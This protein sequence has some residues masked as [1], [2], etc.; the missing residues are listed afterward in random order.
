MHKLEFWSTLPKI[1]YLAKLDSGGGTWFCLNLV[2]Q[3]FVTLKERTIPSEEW[4]GVGWW[5]KVWRQE[6]RKEKKL[7]LGHKIF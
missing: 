2:S 3:N 5:G 7:G 1:G 6:K 4:V